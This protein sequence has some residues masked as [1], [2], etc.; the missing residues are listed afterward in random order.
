MPV[1]PLINKCN[2]K[3]IMCSVPK[4]FLKLKKFDYHSLVSRLEKFHKGKDVFIENYRDSFCITGGEPTLSKY[5]I[6]IIEKINELFPSIPILCLTNGRRFSS[7]NFA[8][9]VLN[10][11]AN[12]EWAVSLHA[13]TSQLH[14]KI[15]QVKG[16]FHQTVRG[17]QNILKFNLR[18]HKVEIRVV[19]HRLNY[20]YLDKIIRFIKTNFI[21]IDRLV[22]IFFELEGKAM[23]NINILK[24]RY[25]ELRPHIIKILKFIK[26]FKEVRFYH[27]P[28]CT[29]PPL[30]YPYIWRTLPSQEVLFASQC[31]FCKLKEVC[32]G[33]P[34]G[35]VEFFGTE[36]FVPIK[37]KNLILKFNENWHHPIREVG[38]IT[39]NF[40][41][42]VQ[43]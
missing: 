2:N 3:C 29:L 1:F 38:V 16:S 39:E 11:K 6:P 4:D 24:L 28:L 14:D 33:I 15:T 30:F 37:R 36:E 20:N 7:L 40:T 9:E 35:Y 21:D 26:Y 8:K 22:F 13:H 12:L 17:L 42:F 43:S 41:Y 23:E 32:L 5:F 19:I 18:R 31:N 25:T 34:K 10:I 27:F